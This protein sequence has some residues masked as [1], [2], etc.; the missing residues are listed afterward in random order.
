MR[1]TKTKI[2]T[3]RIVKRFLILPLSMKDTVI[4][5]ET[6]Y[7]KQRYNSF[8]R[9]ISLTTKEQYDEFLKT[10][11]VDDY[12]IKNTE[13]KDKVIFGFKDGTQRKVDFFT[14]VRGIRN[15]KGQRPISLAFDKSILE[16]DPHGKFREW[17]ETQIKPSM[18]WDYEN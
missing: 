9:D 7:V 1:W 16:N 11:G 4:W 12:L 13:E 5:L 14:G 15:D 17:L 2:D 10:G 8:W 18:G 6:V 3:E